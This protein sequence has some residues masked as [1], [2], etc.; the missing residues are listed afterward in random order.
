[1]TGFGAAIDASGDDE[2]TFVTFGRG[3]RSDECRL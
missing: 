2:G 1:M 3:F